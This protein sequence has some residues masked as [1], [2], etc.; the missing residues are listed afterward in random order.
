[1]RKRY[2]PLSSLKSC[3]HSNDLRQARKSQL[4]PHRFSVQR[5]KSVLPARQTP[6]QLEL[7]RLFLMFAQIRQRPVLLPVL[8]SDGLTLTEP[9]DTAVPPE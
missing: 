2:P 3:Q 5:L 6:A 7:K 4:R 1:M 8:Q 9:Y